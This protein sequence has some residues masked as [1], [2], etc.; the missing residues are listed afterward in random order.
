MKRLLFQFCTSNACFIAINSTR[1]Q[2]GPIMICRFFFFCSS[3]S[4]SCSSS[5]LLLLSFSLSSSSPSPSPSWG[6]FAENYFLVICSTSTTIDYRKF[7][8]IFECIYMPSREY[9]L[10][11]SINICFAFCLAKP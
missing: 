3:V 8:H 4:P 6:H 2:N 9:A 5:L 7:I 1:K 10:K 11:M